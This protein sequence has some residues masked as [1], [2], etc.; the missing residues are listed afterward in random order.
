MPSL[1]LVS[2]IA[3]RDVVAEE[4]GV[5]AIAR[6]QGDLSRV[7]AVTDVVRVSRDSLTVRE[8]AEAEN[9]RQGEQ[10]LA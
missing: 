1:D 7:I 4:L 6:Q 2:I 5:D 3:S 8:H 10:D 9:R